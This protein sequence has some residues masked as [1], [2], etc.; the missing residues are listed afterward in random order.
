ER[1]LTDGPEVELTLATAVAQMRRE[2][3]A[4]A[5]VLAAAEAVWTALAGP[6]EDTGQAL[7]RARADLGALA[8]DPLTGQLAAAEAEHRA[9]RDVLA[10]DPLSLWAADSVDTARRDRLADQV[11]FLAGRAA[12]VAALRAGAD[13]RIAAAAGAVAA[14]RQ[15]SQDARQAHDRAAAII[16]AADLPAPP[17]TG[18][19]LAALTARLATVQRLRDAHRWGQLSAE[20]AAVTQRAADAQQQFRNMEGHVVALSGQRDELRGLLGAYRAK[21]A[22]FGAAEDPTLTSQYRHAR[23]LLWTAPCQLTEADQAVRAYQQSVLAL[24][25]REERP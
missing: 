19:L 5:V 6:L 17:P 7:A 23:D 11:T 14:A 24:P 13:D 25:T 2:Y 21:A 15:A 3:R 12:E 20:L 4:V 1:D 10:A 9:L 8:D 16:A 18:D 22:A